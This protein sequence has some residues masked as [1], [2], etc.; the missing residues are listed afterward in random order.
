MNKRFAYFLTAF[1]LLAAVAI[2]GLNGGVISITS[3]PYSGGGSTGAI[4]CEYSTS[5]DATHPTTWQMK[6]KGST[7]GWGSVRQM[8][9][10]YPITTGSGYVDYEVLFTA[11]AGD[12][13]LGT[14]PAAVRVTCNQLSTVTVH[15]Q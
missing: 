5:S 10:V 13:F 2:A 12:T 7:T 15:Y 6:K 14:N 8:N 3:G 4:K 1:I 9:T 11:P